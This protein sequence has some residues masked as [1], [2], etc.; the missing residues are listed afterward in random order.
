[1]RPFLYLLLTL[2]PAW[3]ALA[4][5][6]NPK[7]DEPKPPKS[8]EYSYIYDL[9]NHSVVRPTTRVLDPALFVRRMSA[10]PREAENVDDQDQVRLPSTWWQPRIGFR[11]VSVEQMLHGPGPG[12]GPAPG[13]WKITQAKTQGVTPGFQIKDSQGDRFIIKFDPPGHPELST[14]A[15]V[16][17]SLLF[18]AAG[19]NVPENAIATFR[20]ESLDIDEEA[21]YKDALGADKPI[22]REYLEELLTRVYR[23]R[24]GSYRCSASR[25]LKGKPL[26]PFKYN[27]RR[28]DD[29]EDRIPH[30]HRRELRGLW[31]IAAW[32]NHCDS[33]GPNSLDM[34]V[35]ANGRSFVRHH[36]IDFSAILGGG[37]FGP[38][39][40]V[41][42][43]EYYVDAHVMTREL[44][45]L[46]LAPFAW[47][48]FV[49]PEIR[50][51]GTVDAAT[52][53]PVHWKPDFPNP[54]YDERT[55]RDI[56]WGARIVAG[57]TDEQIRA[58]VSAGRYT[59]PRAI[60]YLTRV[61]IQRRDQV[62]RAWQDLEPKG[63]HDAALGSAR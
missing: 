27:G 56:R 6:E 24:D 57:F 22:T 61:L 30:E 15:D 58:A 8:R 25:F 35:T 14:S 9:L 54:A 2:L 18:W 52:F 44:L 3:P 40:P 47:E 53:D 16:V 23:Q 62:V 13:R 1:M 5:S 19:Y 37:P 28:H 43:T 7:A 49:D 33:R 20:A 12:K 50:S 59:D 36:L 29:P 41:S 26:G 21:T 45:S 55:T 39:S 11:P 34:W 4:A 17:G 42:G 38:R 51:V 63:R 46:G 31:T 48:D 10:N 60:E 32:V